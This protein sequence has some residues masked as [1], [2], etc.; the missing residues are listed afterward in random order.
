MPI[1]T[2]I[3]TLFSNALPNAS[4]LARLEIDPANGDLLIHDPVS[5]SLARANLGGGPLAQRDFLLDQRSSGAD[6]VRFDFKG[7]MRTLD[8]AT[9]I[10]LAESSGEATAF[11]DSSA[12]YGNNTTLASANVG[13]QSFLYLARKAGYGLEAYTLPDAGNLAPLQILG[14][15]R[16]SHLRNVTA[17]TAV[18]QGADDWLVAASAEENGLSLY[19][20]SNDGR[21]NHGT[22]F[23]F[24]QQLPLTTPTAMTSVDVDGRSYVLVTAHGTSS[25]TVLEVVDG[26]LV[27]RDQ[28]NDSLDTRFAGASVVETLVQGNLALVAVAGNDGGVTLMQMLPGGRLLHRET[29]IDTSSTALDGVTSL[30]FAPQ[31]DGSTDLFVLS[32]GDDGLSRFRVDSDALDVWATGSIGTA[33]KGSDAGECRIL[34]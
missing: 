20:I 10:R 34:R 32:A 13:G 6:K 27:F 11:L 23:G 21:L 22:S 30:Q 16:S 28:V 17:M 9:L 5:Q 7:N 25:L 31:N 29:V 8:Q 26:A 18:A 3:Q 19:R 2:H 33:E 4:A 12:F 1:L 15:T 14:D 24:D